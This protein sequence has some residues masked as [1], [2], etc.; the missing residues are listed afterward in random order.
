MLDLNVFA[1][2]LKEARTKKNMSQAEL[3][4]AIGVSTGTVS[5]YEN[6]NGARYPAFD[7]TVAIAE[8]LGVSIDWLCG[9]DEKAKARSGV[10][11]LKDLLDIVEMFDFMVENDPFGSSIYLKLPMSCGTVISFFKEY[12]KIEPILKDKAIDG[13]LKEGLKKAL[14]EK[15]KDFMPSDDDYPF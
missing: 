14:F 4:K 1:E 6:P 7:K 8:T 5:V 11:I 12:L 10:E 15:F 3:A 13:Y 2:R 9:R